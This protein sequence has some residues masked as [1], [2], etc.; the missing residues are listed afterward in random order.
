MCLLGKFFSHSDSEGLKPA[1]GKSLLAV[2]DGKI[3]E[4]ERTQVREMR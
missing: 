4:M 2:V 1:G 3:E